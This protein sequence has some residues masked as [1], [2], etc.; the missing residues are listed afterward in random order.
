MTLDPTPQRAT[1]AWARWVA[2]CQREEDALP[3]A[4]VRVLTGLTVAGHIAH[5]ALS[6]ALPLVWFDSDHGGLRNL[7]GGVLHAIGGAVPQVV[8]PWCILTFVA[9][10]AMVI[11]LTRWATWA[12]WLGFWVLADLNG[13]A[14]G[15]YDELLTSTLFLLGCS[16]AHRRLSVLRP[17][18]TGSLACVRWLLVGQLVTVYLSTGMQKVSAHWVP[19]GDHMALW[20]ILQQPTWQRIP[21][22]WLAPAAWV[23]R[24]ATVVSWSFEMLA[25]VLLLA[26]W[27][28][29]TRTRPGWV[30]AQFNRLDA[31]TLFLAVG[32]G[33]HIGIEISMEVGAFSLATVALYAACFSPDELGRAASTTLRGV[34][35]R[36][37]GLARVHP[38]S[39]R[40]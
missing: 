32:F 20:Y 29:N 26:F 5:L 11:G 13:Q 36:S 25:P 27:Y 33:M 7:D 2:L 34:G 39:P 18:S 30:R 15:S 17:S 14:G 35:R 10:I 37:P 4:V 8:V 31:R 19:W 9:A 22:F 1:N 24:V 23:T 16:G 38:R 40:P 6:G 21:M 28:R 3:V 12:T